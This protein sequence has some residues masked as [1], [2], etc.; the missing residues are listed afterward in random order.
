M[1]AP[2]TSAGGPITLPGHDQPRPE[3]PTTTRL[4][5]P[6]GGDRPT[7][8]AQ[9]PRL[10]GCNHRRGGATATGSATAWVWCISTI[11]WCRTTTWP[12]T[13]RMTVPTTQAMSATAGEVSGGGEQR[14]HAGQHDA[15]QQPAPGCSQR[16]RCSCGQNVASAAA[17][18]WVFM[19]GAGRWRPWVASRVP[20]SSPPTGLSPQSAFCRQ[21]HPSPSNRSLWSASIATWR[22]VVA[23]G[24]WGRRSRCSGLWVIRRGW[25][26]CGDWPRVKPGWSI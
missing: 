9:E 11:S 19:V 17:N 7:E 10:M 15:T 8:P 6:T 4:Q 13:S 12:A 16:R 18:R 5:H 21:F 23:G 1:V 20:P 26:S 14:G 2:G 25:R 22:W 24:I 3:P